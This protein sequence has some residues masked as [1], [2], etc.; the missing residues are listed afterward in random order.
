LRYANSLLF[1]H[2]LFKVHS[3]GGDSVQGRT[4]DFS[5]AWAKTEGQ[6]IEAEGRQ[7]GVLGE[8]AATPLP[9]G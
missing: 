5:L 1:D 9:T 8:G 3:R 4:Q 7:R 2:A 6:K